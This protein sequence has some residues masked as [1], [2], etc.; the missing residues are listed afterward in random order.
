MV[1][2]P[3]LRPLRAA[4]EA[5]IRE[6]CAPVFEGR[7]YLP[8]VF[9]EWLADPTASFH[10]LEIDGELA[11]FQRVRPLNQRIAWYEGLRVAPERQGLGLGRKLVTA[12]VAHATAHGF[13]ELRLVTANPVAR[14]L[15]ESLGFRRHLDCQSWEATRREGGEP[16]RIP[17]PDAVGPLLQQQIGRPVLTAYAGVNPDTAGARDLDADELARLARL[18]HLR[19]GVGGRALAGLRPSR[20]NRLAATFVVGSGAALEDLLLALR[21]EADADDLDG[22]ALALPVGF[23]EA[24]TL[25]SIGYDL[26]RDAPTFTFYGLRLTP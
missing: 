16:A 22:V 2:E 18:G 13:A 26:R 24:D 6:I 5:R 17:E 14:A 7:D 9:S 10:G 11:A 15:F 1:T 19:A 21:F 12:A 3:E 25:S 8:E 23:P 4:D 20:R